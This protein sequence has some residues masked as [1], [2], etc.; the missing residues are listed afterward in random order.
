VKRPVP[1]FAAAA[2]AALLVAGVGVAVVVTTGPGEGDSLRVDG[3]AAAPVVE[4]PTTPVPT[5]TPTRA[6]STATP[7][8]RPTT[9]ASA[10]PRTPVA[11]APRTAASS[12]ERA[13][14]DGTGYGVAPGVVTHRFD[15]SRKT[16]SASREGISLT[17]TFSTVRA[18]TGQPVTITVKGSRGEPTCCSLFALYG[19][20][21][22]STSQETACP[23]P[24]TTS[25]TATFEHTWNRAG[26]WVLQLQANESS[27]GGGDAY[28][29]MRVTVEIT[30]GT[31]TS[32]GPAKPT[33]KVDRDQ[34]PRPGDDSYAAYYGHA[35]DEDGWI[36]R[37]VLDYGDGTAPRTFGGSPRACQE[38]RGGQPNPS[39]ADLPYDPPHT[40]HYEAPGE[41]VVTLTAY[42]TGCDGRSEQSAKASFTYVAS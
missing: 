17:A 35:E 38:G 7:P 4:A 20:G 30:A 39:Y 16:Y 25:R 23:Q 11:T 31:T 5:A 34:Q 28:A 27:C 8:A 32:N 42:S 36:S 13:P 33:V 18:K 40:H 10:T 19:D 26:K 24:V 6:A 1:A 15:P 9:T 12:P 14:D 3:P 29:L 37:L 41:Y 2:A 22:S 21:Q